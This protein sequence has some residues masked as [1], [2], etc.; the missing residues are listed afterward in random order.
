MASIKTF[1]KEV[2]R[3]SNDLKNEVRN[4]KKFHPEYSCEQEEDLIIKIESNRKDII[5]RLN[6]LSSRDGNLDMKAVIH[7]FQNSVTVLDSLG[8][9]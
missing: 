6:H 2:N 5:A 9:K 7:D 4:Y 8:E 1:K 3:L